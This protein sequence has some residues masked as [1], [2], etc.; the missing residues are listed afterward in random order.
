MPNTIPPPRRGAIVKKAVEPDIINSKE[1]IE[2][3]MRQGP[4]GDVNGGLAILRRMIL[5]DGLVADSDGMVTPAPP[6]AKVSI[7][8]ISA[9]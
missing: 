4:K 1:E 6:V 8:L 5:L 3:L 7:S 2:R 9:S